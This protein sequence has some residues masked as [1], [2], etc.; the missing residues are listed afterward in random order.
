VGLKQEN[1]HPDIKQALLNKTPQ[2]WWQFGV[3][4]AEELK[5]NPDRSRAIERAIV[6]K[7]KSIYGLSDQYIFPPLTWESSEAIRNVLGVDFYV[8]TFVIP[9][10]FRRVLRLDNEQALNLHDGKCIPLTFDNGEVTKL[11]LPK[12]LRVN[13]INT[14]S[15]HSDDT[16]KQIGMH[17]Q[18]HAI[19]HFLKRTPKNGLIGEILARIGQACDDEHD[20]NH[21]IVDED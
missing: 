18:M 11:G 3:T 7:I 16:F 13:L 8:P 5:G 9:Q 14:K 12:E 21:V 4:A 10:N 6:S 20:H 17:E 2:D 15:Y 19:D 1:I